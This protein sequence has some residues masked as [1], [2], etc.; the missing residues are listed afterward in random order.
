MQVDRL[1]HRTDLPSYFSS[2]KFGLIPACE[3]LDQLSILLM[4]INLRHLKDRP[5]LET[6]WFDWFRK[7]NVGSAKMM[8][9]DYSSES[10]KMAISEFFREN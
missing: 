1:R 4:E 5:V 9:S 8:L 3:G 10:M 2:Q 6:Y 7:M